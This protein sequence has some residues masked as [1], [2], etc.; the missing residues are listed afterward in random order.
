[1]QQVATLRIASAAMQML[2][3]GLLQAACMIVFESNIRM[4]MNTFK[5]VSLP[6]WPVQGSMPA[7]PEVAVEVARLH[8]IFAENVKCLA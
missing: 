4:Y 5:T 3:A 7:A 6:Y 2:F 8:K 1:M